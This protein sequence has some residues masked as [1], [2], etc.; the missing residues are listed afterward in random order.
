[1]RRRSDA[2]AMPFRARNLL[3]ASM[4]RAL[5]VLAGNADDD[6]DALNAR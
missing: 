2:R 4:P 3:V 6:P 5:L 1:M